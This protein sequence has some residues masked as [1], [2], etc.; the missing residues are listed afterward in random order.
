LPS[1]V[2]LTSNSNKFVSSLAKSDGHR[3]LAAFYF[4]AAAGFQFPLLVLLHDLMDLAFALGAGTM[5]IFLAWVPPQWLASDC[6][7][8]Y[9]APRIL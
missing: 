7:C 4:L 8:C 6:S 3:L 2:R 5:S 9:G 1:T